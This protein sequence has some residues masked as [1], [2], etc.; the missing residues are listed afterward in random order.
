[1]RVDEPL[2]IR[3]K[4]DLHLALTLYLPCVCLLNR[5]SGRAVKQPIHTLVCLDLITDLLVATNNPI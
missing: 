3:A 4:Q 1:L 5:L 2:R